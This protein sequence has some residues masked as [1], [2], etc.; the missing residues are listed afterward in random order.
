MPLTPSNGDIRANLA[1]GWFA[2]LN[3]VQ[4][5]VRKRRTEHARPIRIA[6]ISFYGVDLMHTDFQDHAASIRANCTHFSGFFGD[7][8]GYGSYRAN[9]VL[10]TAPDVSLYV[11]Q[12][13]G[14]LG[15]R[16][17]QRQPERTTEVGNL[18]LHDTDD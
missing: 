8:D 11:A 12:T 7:R 4:D 18:R 10:K 16:E 17:L 1:D 3:T 5:M 14:L 9:V 6:L 2:Q 13:A 15:S